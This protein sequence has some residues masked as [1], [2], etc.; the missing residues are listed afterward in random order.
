MFS[1]VPLPGHHSLVFLHPFS[2]TPCPV[3]TP[4][5][6]IWADLDFHLLP[7]QG[8]GPLPEATEAAV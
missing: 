6:G 8:P 5:K 1:K 2:A 4:D 3:P 7:Y